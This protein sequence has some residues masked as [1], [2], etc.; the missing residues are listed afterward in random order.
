MPDLTEAKALAALN[1]L[2][3]NVVGTQSASWSN[4]MYPFVAIL[5]AAGLVQVDP[6]EDDLRQHMDCYGG[7]GGYPG[8]ILREPKPG[9]CKPVGRL[10]H[11]TTAA[12]RFLEDPSERN[13][14]ILE[15]VL[16]N[17]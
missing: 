3:S 5:N 15:T 12:R 1:A 4:T 10:E 2:R 7:A 13:R 11:V 14:Q 9:W 8:H 16:G 6:S 17:G